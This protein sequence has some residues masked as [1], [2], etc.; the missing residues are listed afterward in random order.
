MMHR[1]EV[2]AIEQPER[3]KVMNVNTDRKVER[4]ESIV[5]IVIGALMFLAMF[6][7]LAAGG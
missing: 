7:V 6:A 4:V 3:G 2:A 1:C 5:V